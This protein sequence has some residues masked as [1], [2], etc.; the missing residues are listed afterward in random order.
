MDRAERGG[1]AGL[2]KPADYVLY[3]DDSGGE[4][5][6]LRSAA[7]ISGPAKVLLAL[8]R[9]LRRVLRAAGMKELKWTGLRTREPRLQAARAFLEFAA[10]AASAGALRVEVLLWRPSA[11]SPASR[12]RSESQRLRPLYAKLWKRAAGAWPPGRWSVF[13]DQRTGMRWQEQSPALTAAWNRGGGGLRALKEASSGRSAC[14]QLADLL[15]GLARVQ[16]GAGSRADSEAW[17]Q[18]GAL[19][20][21][22][23]DACRRRGLELGSGAGLL[24]AGHPRLS[25]ALLRRLPVR[26]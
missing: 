21:Y 19:R 16:A 8:E 13:P 24:R 4:E 17:R 15:A 10:V 14:V 12:A 23:V 5:D 7:S 11:Q 22:F 6:A 2:R 26:V 20:D 3:C 1:S 25:I 9:E 18:R